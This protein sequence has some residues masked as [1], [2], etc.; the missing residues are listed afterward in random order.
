MMR[1]TTRTVAATN[2]NETCAPITVR[3]YML[4][5]LSRSSLAAVFTL[6][7]TMKRHDVETNLD[8]EK[9][10]GSGSASY[11][12]MVSQLIHDVY[13][14]SSFA[15]LRGANSTGATGQRLKE[16]R[17]S[18]SSYDLGKSYRPWRWPVSMTQR[19]EKKGKTGGIVHT[20]TP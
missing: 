12:S 4:L 6:L 15:G 14:V 11:Q 16:E 5:M 20:V 8:T 19:K 10:S 9:V 2:M 18:I 3:L 7:L 17:T 1:E 13:S